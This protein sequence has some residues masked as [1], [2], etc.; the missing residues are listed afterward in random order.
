MLKSIS[1]FVSVCRETNVLNSLYTHMTLTSVIF[2]L[3][4]YRVGAG[5]SEGVV[6]VKLDKPFEQPVLSSSN[7]KVCV[8]CIQ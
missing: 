5:N 8:L 7:L 3:S 6:K 1:L 2:L 4:I